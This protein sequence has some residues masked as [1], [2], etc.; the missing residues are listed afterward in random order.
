[1]EKTKEALDN[2]PKSVQAHLSIVGLDND[3]SDSEICVV[4]TDIKTR[5]EGIPPDEKLLQEFSKGHIIGTFGTGAYCSMREDRGAPRFRNLLRKKVIVSPVIADQI[6][7][8][9]SDPEPSNAL[10]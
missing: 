10:T 3:L 1:M 4:D 8:P 7:H 5:F 9:P 2:L 6:L